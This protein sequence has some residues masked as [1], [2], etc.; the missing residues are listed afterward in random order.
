ML[1]HLE[2]IAII[3]HSIDD[4][5][6]IVRLVRGFRDDRV[7]LFVCSCR[8]VVG[9]DERRIFHIVR[10]DE[11]QQF[12]RDLKSVLVRIGRKMGDAGLGIVGHCTAQFILGDVLMG[13]GLYH[14]RPRD[15]HVGRVLHHN[16]EIGDRRRI[17][18]SA[19]AW[20][21]YAAYLGDHAARKRVPEKD[22]RVTT[23][24]NDAFLNTGTA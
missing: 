11:R 17:D 5:A 19:C 8:R 13:H 16:V 15:E 14:V 22:V 6:Y 3:H 2:E 23:E 18:G 1:L 4:L 12:A 21:H 10:G 7:K 9:G 20:P 24:R